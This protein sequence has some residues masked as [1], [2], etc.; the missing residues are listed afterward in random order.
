MFAGALGP[1]LLLVLLY[2]AMV[3]WRS[4]GLPKAERPC[5]RGARAVLLIAKDI[6]PLVALIGVVLGSILTGLTTPTE[7]SGLGVVGACLIAALYGRFPAQSPV[8][9]KSVRRGDVASLPDE[10][11]D[12]LRAAAEEVFA[13]Q[14]ADDDLFRRT[15]ESCRAFS[16]EYDAYQ[17]ITAFDRF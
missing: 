16:E 2:L 17:T 1:G 9:E 3:L 15:R 12:A 8:L 10:V 6:L 4:R 5:K 13:E 14:S 7:A 11:L